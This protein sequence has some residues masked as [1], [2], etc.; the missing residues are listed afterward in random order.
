MRD[1][2]PLPLP[3][4]VQDRLAGSTVFTTLDLHNGYW[5]LLLAP[6]DQAKTA[7]CPGSGLGLYQF[8]RMPFGLTGAPG[9][10]QCLMDSILRGL[11]FATT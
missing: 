10:F 2:Y 8:H 6:E 11:P 9:S 7:F 1:A 4:E 3:D 5:Q